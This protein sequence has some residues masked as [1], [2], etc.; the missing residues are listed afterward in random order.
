MSY[1]SPDATVTHKG[2]IATDLPMGALD[3]LRPTSTSIAPDTYTTTVRQAY[4]L[5]QYLVGRD[6]VTVTIRP[7]VR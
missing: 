7:V 1:A 3:S 5:D 4:P 2:R 6:R